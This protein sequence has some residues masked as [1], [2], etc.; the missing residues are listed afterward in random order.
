MKNLKPGTTYHYRLVAQ[1]SSG[2]AFG[3]DKTFST[4]G[5]PSGADRCGGQ[6]SV[7]TP[8]L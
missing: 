3:G 2:K 8:G 1:N 6:A 4:V 7:L 5:A